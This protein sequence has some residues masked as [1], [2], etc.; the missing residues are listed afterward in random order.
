MWDFSQP[1]PAA[2]RARIPLTAAQRDQ[3]AKVAARARAM[4]EI[5][6]D[7]KTAPRPPSP[8]RTKPTAPVGTAEAAELRAFL[9]SRGHAISGVLARAENEQARLKLARAYRAV[10]TGE[11]H[12]QAAWCQLLASLGV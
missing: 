3:Q 2:S 9:D 11:P 6:E 5:L 1:K 10:V 7:G 8:R 12:A 4:A